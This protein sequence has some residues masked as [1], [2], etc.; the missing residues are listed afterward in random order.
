M[1]KVIYLLQIYYKKTNKR[2]IANLSIIVIV[3]A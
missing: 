2:W 3:F 1:N